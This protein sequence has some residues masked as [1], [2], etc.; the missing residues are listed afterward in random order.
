MVDVIIS[1]AHGPQSYQAQSGLFN[2]YTL[3]LMWS[4]LLR[5]ELKYKQI[6]CLVINKP[7]YSVKAAFINENNPKLC[8]EIHFNSFHDE[9]VRGAETLFNPGSVLGE[10]YA[11]IMQEQLQYLPNKNRGIKEGWYRSKKGKRIHFLQ[12]TRCPALIIEPGFISAEEELIT[13]A[14][15]GVS[16]IAK[17]IVEISTN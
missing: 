12:N 17:A 16:L 7:I 2:E 6:N 8:L 9:T 3:S 15:L 13:I 14:P 4:T 1:V 5:L 10:K 11:R